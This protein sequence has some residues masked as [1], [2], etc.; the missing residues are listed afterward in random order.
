MKREL[1]IGAL[2]EANKLFA[3][4]TEIDEQA[5]RSRRG[6]TLGWRDAGED[7]CEDRRRGERHPDGQE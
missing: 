7:R 2:A 6:P 5:R 1:V 3:T 4:E